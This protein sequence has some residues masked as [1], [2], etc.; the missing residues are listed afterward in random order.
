[1]FLELQVDKSQVNREMCVHNDKRKR[2]KKTK[3]VSFCLD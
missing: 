2:K 3:F 1:M